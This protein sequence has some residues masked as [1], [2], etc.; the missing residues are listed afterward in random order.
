[1]IV[2]LVG[3]LQNRNMMG[4]LNKSQYKSDKNISSIQLL[5]LRPHSVLGTCSYTDDAN[6]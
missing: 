4:R 1:M 6:E 3:A 2:L 5:I